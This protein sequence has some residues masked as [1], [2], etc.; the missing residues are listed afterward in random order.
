MARLSQRELQVFQSLG[1]QHGVQET[2]QILRISV[3]TV[4]TYCEHLKDKL[5]LPTTE[6]LKLAA[7][8]WVRTGQLPDSS[9]P[10]ARPQ[11][12]PIRKP[13]TNEH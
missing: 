1:A 9:P 11:P 10:Q 7:S 12:V 13:A 6:A 5:A 2:A 4:E 3:K 8:C